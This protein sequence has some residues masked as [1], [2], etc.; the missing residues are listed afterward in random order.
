[1]VLSMTHVQSETWI[2]GGRAAAQVEEE[3]A[4]LLQDAGILEPVTLLLDTGEVAFTLR[5]EGTV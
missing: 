4:T 3:I 1:M 2:L 5:Q